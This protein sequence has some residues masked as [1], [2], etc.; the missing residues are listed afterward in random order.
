MANLNLN[1]RG[2]KTKIKNINGTHTIKKN[3]MLIQILLCPRPISISAKKNPHTGTNDRQKKRFSKNSV[4]FF[5]KDN[6]KNYIII[7][8]LLVVVLKPF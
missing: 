2:L 4:S 1:V 5:L 6:K 3:E 8:F 7:V